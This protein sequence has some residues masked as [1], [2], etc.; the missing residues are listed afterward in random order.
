[1]IWIF[2][3][4]IFCAI[5]ITIRVMLMHSSDAEEEKKKEEWKE[6]AKKELEEW[7]KHHAE[8]INKTKTTNR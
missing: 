2:L 6:A 3:T 4:D 8:T 1:M 7:Y 5:W